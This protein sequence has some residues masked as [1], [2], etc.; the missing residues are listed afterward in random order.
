M[1]ESKPVHLLFNLP[2]KNIINERQFVIAYGILNWKLISLKYNNKN[3]LL[4][5]LITNMNQFIYI[6]NANENIQNF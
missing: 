6:H 4:Y 3:D 1:L 2:L 5:R